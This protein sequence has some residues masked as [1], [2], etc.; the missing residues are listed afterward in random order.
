MQA[1][2]RVKSD[3]LGDFNNQPIILHGKHLTVKALVQEYHRRFHHG[4]NDAV[5]NELRQSYF[6][7]GLRAVLKSISSRCIVCRLQRGKPFNPIMEN[8]PD[9]R[10]AYRQRPF[11]HCGVDYFG[12]MLVTI[13]RRREKRWGALF[14]CLTTRA[15]HL[16]IA[17]TLNADSAIMAIQRMAARRGAP[18]SLYSDCGSNFKAADKELKEAVK[19][20]DNEKMTAFALN[21]NISWHFNSPDAAFQGGSWERLVCEVKTALRVIL[22]DQAPREEVLITVLTEAE[23][24]VNSRPLTHVSLDPRDNEAL[25]PNHFLI[26]TSSAA[27]NLG[28]ANPNTFFHKK[29]VEN[30]TTV[31]RCLLE[32]V[33][34]RIPTELD[35]A[36]KMERK[37]RSD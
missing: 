21:K 27:I 6:I 8:L 5:R 14:T 32:K 12:P 33:A 17:H 34:S 4:S 28:T 19:A 15:I 9:G 2:G 3:L 10:L 37:R 24:S 16:E 1:N 30:R 23:H 20:I 36:T 13:G 11:M 22:K 26:G 7:F 25:T 35:N 29:T 31:C 18:A